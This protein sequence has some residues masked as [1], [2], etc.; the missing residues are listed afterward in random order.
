MDDLYR[1]D[2]GWGV[3][4]LLDL[5]YHD[6]QSMIISMLEHQSMGRAGQGYEGSLPAQV[7]TLR[8]HDGRTMFS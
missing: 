6:E 1:L 8:F 5:L 2:C 3:S 4:S 7:F